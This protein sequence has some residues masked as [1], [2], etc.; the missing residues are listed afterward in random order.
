MFFVGNKYERGG[1]WVWDL[2]RT[3]GGRVE[4]TLNFFKDSLAPTHSQ[5]NSATAGQQQTVCPISQANPQ[6]AD[7]S[8]CV[9]PISIAHNS[10]GGPTV[11]N[12]HQCTRAHTSRAHFICLPGQLMGRQDPH[13][14][15]APVGSNDAD[16][17]AD[18]IG[19][20]DSIMDGVLILLCNPN[21]TCCMCLTSQRNQLGLALCSSNLTS[22]IP[23]FSMLLV[24]MNV[25]LCV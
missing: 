16:E 21:M 24:F 10:T 18:N 17:S 25:F 4:G 12:D 6:S 15:H 8:K 11:W 20:D 2:K 13:P 22:L 9:C 3:S 19:D 5:P 1:Y 23:A 7:A 14:V